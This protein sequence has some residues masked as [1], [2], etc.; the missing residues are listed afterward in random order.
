MSLGDAE[1]IR[2]GYG[3]EGKW[4]IAAS[5]FSGCSALLK[6]VGIGYFCFGEVCTVE[7][8]SMREGDFLECVSCF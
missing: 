6:L 2:V 7:E 8:N 3:C 5:G 1:D 4:R